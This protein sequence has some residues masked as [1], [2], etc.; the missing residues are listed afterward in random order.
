MPLLKN[1]MIVASIILAFG[2]LSFVIYNQ[3][4]SAKQQAAIQQQL[5]QQKTL[6]DGLVQSANQYT[7]KSDLQAF[8]Q[9]NTGDLKAIQNNLNSL[10]AQLTAANVITAD[11][12]GQSASNLPSSSTGGSTNPNPVSPVVENC[13][14]GGTVTCPTT[15]PYGYD[16][17]QQNFALSEDFPS[18]KIPFGTAS[19][20]AWQADPWSINV[21]PR[22][23]KVTSIVGTDE[24]QRVYIDNKF[25]ITEGTQTYTVPIKTDQTEQV[26]PSPKFSWWN[27]QLAVGVDG[28]LSLT[29]FPGIQGE[30]A[31]SLN[32]GV[33]SY[34]KYKTQPDV[35]VLQLGAAYESVTKRPGLVITPVALSL[36]ILTPLLHN[37]YIAP[38][39][40]ISTDG[41]VY[42]DVGLRLQ[43]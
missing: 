29:R 15:D 23:Y 26:F 14:N 17:T 34:G 30:V 32:F 38:S 37:T 7:T 39:V 43:L 33:M 36:G 21:E 18:L 6:V 31:P 2:A 20:S 22:E 16:H 10:G 28:G 9:Q 27:P 24:N 41:T 4:S 12:T 19:F 1:I 40:H 8:I 11:S 35:S 42:G 5:I 13:P 3:A 25:T